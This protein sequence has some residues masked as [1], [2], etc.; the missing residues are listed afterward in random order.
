MS[1]E[2]KRSQRL[3]PVLDLANLN[4]DKAEAEMGRCRQLLVQEQQKLSGLISYQNEYHEMVHGNAA[5]PVAAH[6][7]QMTQA[8]LKQLKTAIE[9]QH[10]YIETIEQQLEMVTQAWRQ[11]YGDSEAIAKVIDSA[12]V[13]ERAELDRKQQNETDDIAQ[14]RFLSRDND[15]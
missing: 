9:Q 14:M 1:P 3:K 8:F 15:S 13:K 2:K 11:R 10:A 5:A 6:Q 12:R 4:R 7:L